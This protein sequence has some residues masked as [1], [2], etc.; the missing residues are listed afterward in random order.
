MKNE[1]MSL[2]SKI[3]TFARTKGIHPQTVM[4]NYMFEQFMVRLSKTKYSQNL[5]LKGGLLIASLVD[6]SNRSTMDFDATLKDLT[7][8]EDSIFALFQEINAVD[9]NNE[10]S[11]TIK[12][13][14]PIRDDDDYGGLRVSV[15]VKYFSL[16][17]ILKFDLSTGDAITPEEV[18]S[19]Y[20]IM[21]SDDMIKI[22]SYNIETILAEKIHSIFYHYLGTTRMRDYYDVYILTELKSDA[23][24]FAVLG[25][26]LQRTAE[27]RNTLL[28]F[29]NWSDKLS[30][31]RSDEELNRL[32]DE[33]SVKNNYTMG[34]TFSMMV[35][36][37]E[38]VL[39]IAL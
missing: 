24:D 3:N 17:S 1:T 16:I 32:W 27:H 33:Y 19:T 12:K 13:V 28:V 26:A 18:Q 21:F 34:L 39:S 2:K 23:I 29:D 30:V 36:S 6:I 11:F 8:S 15:E 9:S 31:L 25:Q 10:I 5:I 20:P 22:P 37:V 35:E 38:S 4:Q 7:L 14:S